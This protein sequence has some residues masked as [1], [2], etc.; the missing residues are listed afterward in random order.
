MKIAF[1]LLCNASECYTDGNPLI[2]WHVLKTQQQQQQN[3]DL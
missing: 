2:K 1:F 3:N